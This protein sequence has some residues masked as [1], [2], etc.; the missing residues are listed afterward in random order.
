MERAAQLGSL[1][2]VRYVAGEIDRLDQ[3]AIAGV[4]LKGLLTV[5]TLDVR[6]RR[7]DAR[8]SEA[9]RVVEPVTVPGDWRSVLSSMGYQLERRPHRG[10][11]ARHDGRPIAVVHPK[12]Q[13]SEFAR[14]GPDGRPAEGVLITDCH[15]EGGALWHDDS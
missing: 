5:H 12:A 10:W 14:L 11:L 9:G 15:A 1:D 2:A 6:L 13:M 3:T 4:K 8:W 7:D